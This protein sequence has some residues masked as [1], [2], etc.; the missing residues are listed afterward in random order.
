MRAA[1]PLVFITGLVIGGCS[2]TN[3]VNVDGND[4]NAVTTALRAEVPINT[5][6]RRSLEFGI[7]S[8]RAEGSQRLSGSD[9][10]QLGGGAIGGGAQVDSELDLN[11][12]TVAYRQGVGDPEQEA[13]DLTLFG[14]LGIADTEIELR[15]GSTLLTADANEPY[16]FVGAEAVAQVNDRLLLRGRLSLPLMG[17]TRPIEIELV[18]GLNWRGL[19][20]WGGWRMVDLDWT[21]S[22][23]D[24]D[25]RISGP[26]LSVGFGF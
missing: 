9:L 6:K 25:Y 17:A 10:I 4:S 13:L 22:G 19:T 16:V 11:L 7:A 24:V 8:A 14:G 20:L 5:A 15:S 18:G 23:S 21:R 12:A 3:A 2:G 26:V 1:L